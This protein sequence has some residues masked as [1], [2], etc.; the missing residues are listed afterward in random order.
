M[1]NGVDTLH[2]IASTLENRHRRIEE[3]PPDFMDQDSQ[4]GSGPAL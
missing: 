1:M 4:D 2:V 3:Q